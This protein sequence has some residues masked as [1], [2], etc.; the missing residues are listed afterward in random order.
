M[1]RK[2][3]VILVVLF[4]CF[5][6]IGCAGNEKGSGIRINDVSNQ[7]DIMI[8]PEREDVLASNTEQLDEIGFNTGSEVEVDVD[9]T[10]LS[11][12]LVYAEVYNIM[13]SPEKYIG[14][15]VKMRGSYY[16]SYYEETGKYYHYVIIEDAAACCQQGLEFIWNGEHTYPENY[17]SDG[18]EVEVVGTFD[19]YEELGVSYSY[20]STDEVQ[21]IN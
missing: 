7:E 1:I 14:K 3:S 19:T 2:L 4:L 15:T 5:L 18:T 9:L 16:A 13:V 8:T 20:I 6:L 10:V 11:S 17:P 12:T 21:I